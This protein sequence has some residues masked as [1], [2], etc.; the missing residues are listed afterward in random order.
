MA[1]NHSCCAACW[2][3]SASAGSAAAAVNVP[4]VLGS[5]AASAIAA[6]EY[7]HFCKAPRSVLGPCCSSCWASRRTRCAGG[8][9]LILPAFVVACSAGTLVALGRGCCIRRTLRAS[10]PVHFKH[11]F[12]CENT[13]EVYAGE[14]VMCARCQPCCCA[15]L[16]RRAAAGCPLHGLRPLLGGFRRVPDRVCRW[17]G[18]CTIT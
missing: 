17:C 14:I 18:G 8:C 7:S 11:Q 13:A 16:L 5:P 2:M 15:V 1:V 12:C 4:A 9:H 6:I 10:V 3:V